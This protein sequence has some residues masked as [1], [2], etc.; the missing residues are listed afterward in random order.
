[1]ANEQTPEYIDDSFRSFMEQ[2][3]NIFRNPNMTAAIKND[4]TYSMNYKP[5]QAMAQSLG[6][7][8]QAQ[9]QAGGPTS[10]KGI[11]DPKIMQMIAGLQEQGNVRADQLPQALSQMNYQTAAADQMNRQPQT[12]AMRA[13]FDAANRVIQDK[14]AMSRLLTQIGGQKEVKKTVP[15]E[16][17]LTTSNR[18]LRNEIDKVRLAN[19]LN[20]TMTATQKQA[21]K[22]RAADDKFKV[23]GRLGALRQRLEDEDAEHNHL[24]D[25]IEYN[26]LARDDYNTMYAYGEYSVPGTFYGT[27][28]KTGPRR[29]NLVQTDVGTVRELFDMMYEKGMTK[30]DSLAG[31]L[32]DLQNRADLKKVPIDIVVIDELKRLKDSQR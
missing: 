28:S 12:D 2:A 25:T 16:S 20:P 8:G 14:G 4:G 24:S 9:Q 26:N 13:L 23:E 3:Y 32:N 31:F 18:Q 27:N 11:M 19:A 7:Q 17:A 30:E 6:A 21:A 10:L 29:I 5:Q 22:D 1:M 15:G